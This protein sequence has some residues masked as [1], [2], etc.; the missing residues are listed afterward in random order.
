MVNLNIKKSKR[1]FILLALTAMLSITAFNPNIF[2]FSSS[3]NLTNINTPNDPIFIDEIIAASYSSD[4]GN[5]GENLNISLHQSKIDVGTPLFEITNA[6]DSNNNTFYIDSPFESTFNSTLS[7]I[8]VE[9]IYAPNQTL[10]IEDQ[11]SW[12]QPTTSKIWSS[13]EVIGDCYLENISLSLQNTGGLG[14]E[15]YQVQLYNA[16]LWNFGGTD[17]IKHFSNQRTIGTYNQSY[18]AGRIWFNITNIHEALDVDNTYNNTFFIAVLGLTNDNGNWDF[19]NE[20]DGTDDS[21]VWDLA[22][23]NTPALPARDQLMKIDLSPNG[24]NTPFPTEISLKINNNIVENKDYGSGNVTIAKDFTSLPTQ[25]DYE[26]TAEWW[27]VSCNITKIQANYTKSDLKSATSFTVQGS[28]QDINWNTTRI[29]GLNFFDSDFSNYKINFSVPANWQNLQAF[30]GIGNNKTDDTNL[31][32]I[33]GGYRTLQII[34][35]GNGTYWFI[36]AT[37]NNLLHTIHTYVNSIEKETVNYTDT[38]SFLANFTEPIIDGNINLTV[39]SPA[40][41]YYSNHTYANASLVTDSEISLQDWF[42][43]DNATDN[44]G[45]YKIQVYWNNGTAAGF[46]EKDLTIIAITDLK[47]ISPQSGKEYFE[48]EIFDI[49]LFYNDTGYNQGD[50]GIVSATVTENSGSLSGPSTNGTDGYYIYNLNTSDYAFGWN[51]I[52]F[53]AN[54]TYFNNAITDFTFYLRVNTTITPSNTKDFGDVIKGQNR[55]YYFNYADIYFNPIQEAIL[56]VVD[57]PSGFDASLSEDSI[58]P[59]NYSIELDTSGVTAS[60][61]PYTC[62]FNITAPRN[63]TQYIYLTLTVTIA[64]TGIEIISKND[65]LVQKDGLNQTILFS[66]NNT[67]I[68]KGISGLDVSNVTVIDNQTLLPRPSIWLYTTAT[69]GE[70]ILNVSVSDLISGWIQLEINASL[71]PNYNYT[72]ASFDFYL[73]GNTTKIDLI[74]IEDQD[75]GVTLSGIGKNYNWFIER[76]LYVTLNISDLDNND[77]LLTGDAD[78]Y[79]IEFVEIGNPTNFGTLGNTLDFVIASNTYKGDIFTS[80]LA[81]AGSYTINITIKLDN[82]EA[83]IY[84]FNLTIIERYS[85]ILNPINPPDDV[86]AGEDF[87]IV[88]KAEYFNGSEWLPIEGSNIVITPYFNN[89]SASP[90]GPFSTNISGEAEFVIIVPSGAKSMNLSIYMASEYNHQDDTLWINDIEVIPTPRG[91]T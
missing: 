19:E 62:I 63:E 44:Y 74:S 76:D 81:N 77:N 33:V 35:A 3:Y 39:Y 26:L 53:E 48:G 17:Y 89:V 10:N 6:S 34:N 25:L 73:R 22:N 61:V 43:P 88:I 2:N 69:E 1:I 45:L 68:N 46:L 7:Q 79:L 49:T 42:I 58:T 23:P 47:L 11:F 85:I 83:A 57:L 86:K 71:P 36:N 9:D 75:A 30:N 41:G 20:G 52:T 40:P 87:T 21:I 51:S 78:S 82:Y 84:N 64:Q 12:T 80:N 72:T 56:S 60:V 24:G 37:S 16:Q 54:K 15:E 13:F 59:G 67:D 32:P 70:Y 65:I 66:F 31:G 8:F 55:T 90:Y 27:D 38:V 50:R 5:S 91:M 4:Y 28:G 29:G 18:S 14:W